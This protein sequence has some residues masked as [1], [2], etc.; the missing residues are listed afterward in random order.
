MFVIGKGGNGTVVSSHNCPLV[1]FKFIMCDDENKKCSEPQ[2]LHQLKFF[3]CFSVVAE[4]LEGFRDR[5][6]V[7]EPMDFAQLSYFEGDKKITA[8]GFKMSRIF[9]FPEQEGKIVQTYFGEEDWLK[10]Y[11]GRG[12]YVG[13]NQIRDLVETRESGDEVKRTTEQK[14]K[15]LVTDLGALIAI[16]NLQCHVS[17]LDVEV[18]LGRCN[19]KS[20]NYK[21]YIIDFDQTSEISTTLTKQDKNELESAFLS[22][23]YWPVSEDQAYSENFWTGYFEV[24]SLLGVEEVAQEIKDLASE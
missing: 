21:L 6:C 13:L 9:G 16:L 22:E 1:A 14:I 18:V 12:R 4:Q 8:S 23:P 5:V 24:A 7:L 17:H 3:N 19:E 2:F 15:Q 20:N 11:P 10:D